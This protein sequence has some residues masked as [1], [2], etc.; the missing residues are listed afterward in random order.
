MGNVNAKLS[1]FLA[2]LCLMSV[3][4]GDRF[5]NIRD[6]EVLYQ[7]NLGKTC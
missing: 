1:D 2:N 5:S 3:N 6:K 4:T 7:T